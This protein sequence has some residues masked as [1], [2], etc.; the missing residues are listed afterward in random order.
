[1]SMQN[2]GMNEIGIFVI[3]ANVFG[4]G[5]VWWHHRA[6]R[7]GLNAWATNE[8][9]ILLEVRYVWPFQGPDAWRRSRNQTQFRINVRNARGENLRGWVTLGTYWGFMDW[10]KVSTVTWK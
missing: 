10:Y 1:L 3:L 6:C 8:H 2:T 4:F 7:N 5:M 9:L